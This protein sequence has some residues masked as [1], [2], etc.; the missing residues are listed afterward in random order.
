MDEEGCGPQYN[1]R[2]YC[3][4]KPYKQQLIHLLWD[5]EASENLT[6]KQFTKR[7][8]NLCFSSNFSKILP[9]TSVDRE[10]S[11]NKVKKLRHHEFENGGGVH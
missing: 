7:N 3:A 9:V 4:T 10:L 11:F 8:K 6:P 1:L 2:T 5:I